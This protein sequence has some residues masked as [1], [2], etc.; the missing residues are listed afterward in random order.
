MGF[1]LQSYCGDGMKG[2]SNLLDPE[3]YGCLGFKKKNFFCTPLYLRFQVFF[4][5]KAGCDDSHLHHHPTHHTRPS[6]IPEPLLCQQV[7]KVWK[8]KFLGVDTDIADVRI[9]RCVPLRDK[10]DLY[11]FDHQTHVHVGWVHFDGLE[12]WKSTLRH[13]NLAKDRNREEIPKNPHPTSPPQKRD[14]QHLQ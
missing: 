14:H 13:E 12:I 8:W 2:P 7:V 6:G 3:G 11:E 1:T 9:Y 5:N 10:K 4:V